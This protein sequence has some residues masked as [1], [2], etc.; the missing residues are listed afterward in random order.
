MVWKYNH[1][2]AVLCWPAGDYEGV[3]VDVLDGASRAGDPMYTLT[4][5]CYNSNGQTVR[6]KE[7]IVQT[8]QW[9]WKLKKWAQAVGQED[10]F[11]ADAFNIEEHVGA[12]VTVSLEIEAQE[13]YDEKNVIR[14]VKPLERTG[15]RPAAQTK[16][17]ITRKDIDEA[18]GGAA[19]GDIP[20]GPAFDGW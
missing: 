2:D 13:G 5:E 11:K 18:A 4:I 9:V 19:D 16:A 1:K 12:N 14:G 20:F 3:L 8:P 15:S 6:I 10:T 17:A 7:Y